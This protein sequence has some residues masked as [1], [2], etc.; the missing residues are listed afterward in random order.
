VV[1]RIERRW[2]STTVASRAFRAALTPASWLFGFGVG[3]RNS[4][5]DSGLFASHS[6]G[7]PTISIGNLTV[8][9]TGKTPIASWFAARIIAAGGKPAILLRGYGGDEAKV[10]AML[11]PDAIIV[12]DADRI[13]GAARARDLGA[14]AIVLDDGF[15]HR[16]AKR[17]A[18]V[19]LLSADRHRTVRLLPSGPFREPWDSLRRATHIIVTRKRTTPL[20]A[21]E[22][23]G[24]ATRMAPAAEGAIAHLEAESLFRVDH[25][26]RMA[27]GDLAGRGVLAIAGIGDPRSFEA[28][29]RAVSA[30]VALRA[31]GDHHAYSRADAERL[32][33]EAEG[34]HFAVCTLKDAVKLAPFWPPSA[35][36]LWYLS[37]RVIMELGG[38]AMEGLAGRLARPA[39]T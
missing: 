6:L 26:E 38:E 10:H 30:R 31:F 24:Y 25:S 23:L 35:P 22:V 20:H 21:K 34:A 16:R 3:L 33:R 2:E 36:P 4:W 39:K 37:Q 5:Y 17:D 13:R 29:L 7:L 18:D 1:E 14:T 9:G 12:A 32:A 8:G 15:Q 28:Q 11:V 19:V 27:I